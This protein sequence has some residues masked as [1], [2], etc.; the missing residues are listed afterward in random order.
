MNQDKV[1]IKESCF[2]FGESLRDKL[3]LASYDIMTVNLSSRPIYQLYQ[4]LDFLFIAAYP[5]NHIFNF[6]K[7]A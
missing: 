7:S 6:S 3:Y 5:L 2:K 4:I 1:T